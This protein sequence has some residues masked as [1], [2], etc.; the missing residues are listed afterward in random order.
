MQP[1]SEHEHCLD[2]HR[3]IQFLEDNPHTIGTAEW[4]AMQAGICPLT[5]PAVLER[6]IQF[7]AV[8]LL[9]GGQRPIYCHHMHFCS[10]TQNTPIST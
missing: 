4:L 6:L 8:R 5:A 2:A 1:V 10:M 3:M 7:G 9:R